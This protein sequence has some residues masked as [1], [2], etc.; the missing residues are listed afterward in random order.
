MS[1]IRV[2]PTAATFSGYVM[3]VASSIS[4]PVENLPSNRRFFPFEMVIT[5]A[6]T[7]ANGS[8]ALAFTDEAS[9][10]TVYYP[11][12]DRLN[13]YITGDELYQFAGRRRCVQCVYD[14]L[15]KVVRVCSCLSPIVLKVPTPPAAKEESIL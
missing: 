15:F 10:Y 1:A 13:K 7:N 2:T 5:E 14:N 9:P 12:V 6:F 3:L 4:T 11:L 8:T